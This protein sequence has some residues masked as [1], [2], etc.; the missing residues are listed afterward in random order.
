MIDLSNFNSYLF[1]SAHK[2]DVTNKF[3]DY[4]ADIFIIDLEDSLPPKYKLGIH[5]KLKDNSQL[6]EK[7][8]F[9]YRVNHI[10]TFYGLHDIL[11]IIK[12]KLK[13]CVIVLPNVESID[14]VIITR[15]HLPNI[16]IISTIESSVGLMQ[17][18]SIAK[19]SDALLFGSADYSSTFGI[20]PLFENL[21]YPRQVISTA[22]AA[23]GIP[24]IDTACFNLNNND[25]LVTECTYIK[26]IGFM[27]KAAIHPKQLAIINQYLSPSQDEIEWAKNIVNILTNKDEISKHNDQMIGPPFLNIAYSILKQHSKGKNHG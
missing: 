26:K 5:D 22:A 8:T 19:V 10:K 18:N 13:P 12:S 16:K 7:I 20:L 24:A 3:T 6:L 2:L 1:T 14:E 23:A 17:V 27:S 25:E 21:V 9:G 4:A 11:S 15:S